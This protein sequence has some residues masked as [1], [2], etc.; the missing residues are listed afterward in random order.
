MAFIE[1]F[2]IE[3]IGP[4]GPLSIEITTDPYPIGT[5]V[6]ANISL[7][8]IDTQWHG[9]VL[10][11]PYSAAA[12]ITSFTT[13]LPDGT[14]SPP[15]SPLNNAFGIKNVARITF[16]L[17]VEHASAMAQINVLSLQ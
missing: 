16:A 4:F 9:Q 17:G 3:A 14:E 2:F 11:P 5:D 7:S 1:G 6:Y 13:Y 8:S 12:E 15:L 10:D